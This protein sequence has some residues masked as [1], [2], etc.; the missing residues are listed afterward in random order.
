MTLLES[1]SRILGA[2]PD[3]VSASA[4]AQLR[5][6]GVDVRT[7]VRVVAADAHGFVLDGGEQIPAAL[8]VWAAGVRASTTLEKS[9]LELNRAGQVVV[10]RNLLASERP[11][12]LCT[13]RLRQ[14]HAGR[15]G[16]AAAGDRAGREPAG[17][18]PDT[19]SA[20]MAAGG[21][22]VPAFYFRDLGA[23]VALSD[24]N[25]FGTL[26]RFG[27]FRARFIKGQ[28]ARLSHALLYRRYQLALHGIARAVLFG[29]PKESTHSCSRRSESPD[30][31]ENSMRT[32][33]STLSGF[34]SLPGTTQPA[35][36]SWSSQDDRCLARADS[37]SSRRLGHTRW[38]GSRRRFL[39]Q[40]DQR[41]S[42]GA[43]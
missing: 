31:S 35:A 6:L 42:R 16:S 34:A 8:K 39:H 1:G 25:A 30:R 37:A 38:R 21:Q 19:P 13:G 14:F 36:N 29:W 9:G 24:Y 28:F 26:G 3:A 11:G 41:D 20:G 23:L 17:V 5:A 15:R 32:R 22:A 40:E 27:F 43:G 33:C 12:D 7:G 18:A 2:F 4:A 10:Q